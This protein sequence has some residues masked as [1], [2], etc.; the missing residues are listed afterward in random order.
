MRH[1]KVC[2][3]TIGPPRN[4]NKTL[5][6]GATMSLEKNT[7]RKCAPKP[8]QQQGPTPTRVESTE[9]HETKCAKTREQKLS[10]NSLSR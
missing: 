8:K 6:Q 9:V 1:T 2:H 3:P 5:T 4:L 7:I 10:R